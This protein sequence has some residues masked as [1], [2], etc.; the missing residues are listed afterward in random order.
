MT[1]MRMD[2]IIAKKGDITMPYITVEAGKLTDEQ[3]KQLM[4]EL[5]I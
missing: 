3:K 2:G 1:D 4:K 5:T